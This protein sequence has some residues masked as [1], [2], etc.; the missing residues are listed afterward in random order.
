MKKNIIIALAACVALA[1]CTKN[2][3]KPVA[4]DQQITFQAVVNKPS[5]K[6]LLTG[7][8][9]PTGSTFGTVAYKVKGVN[10]ELY[11][12]VSEVKYTAGSPAY[13]ST[14]AAYYWPKESGSSLTFYS[15]SPFKYSESGKNTAITVTHTKDGLTF[16]DY[17][18]KEHQETDLMVA[19]KQAD[20]TGNTSNAGGSWTQG[21]PTVF[22]HMLAQ[23][24]AINFRT[25]VDAS[26]TPDVVVKD[27]ANGRDGTSGKEYK[28]GDK[29]FVITGVYFEKFHEQGTLTA[30][31]SNNWATSGSVTNSYTWYSNETGAKFINGECTPIDTYYLVLPQTHA[32]DAMLHV[33]YEIHTYTS[34]NVHATEKMDVSVPLKNLNAK[35][36]M[37]K[38]YTYTL[39]IDLDRIYWDPKVTEWTPGT[40]SAEI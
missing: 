34:A 16:E 27:Y 37:N 33:T 25:V 18:V 40:G 23:I 26:A 13:W 11:I 1:G 19:E 3:P 24:V 7:T 39:N 14:E 17:S 22:H 4:V 5:S 20:Q 36:E 9:Y 2:E 21:V 29:Q 6:A 10:S 32:D 31:D 15:Y 12:P 8:T 38:K 30:G 35:W 28:A